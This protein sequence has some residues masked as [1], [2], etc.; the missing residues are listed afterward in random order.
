MICKHFVD[1]IF[2]FELICLCTVKWL[3]VFPSNMNNSM[4][5]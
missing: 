2:K 5:Y 3:Q 1:F 4:Y